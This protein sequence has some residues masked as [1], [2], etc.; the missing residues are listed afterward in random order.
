MVEPALDPLGAVAP[1][2]EAIAFELAIGR[3][4]GENEG[5]HRGPPTSAGVLPEW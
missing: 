3:V 1:P 2:A 5:I 4:T